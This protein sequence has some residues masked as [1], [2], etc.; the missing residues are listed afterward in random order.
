MTERTAS[1]AALVAGL[2]LLASTPAVAQGPRIAV[3]PQLGYQRAVDADEGR[4]MVGAALRLRVIPLLGAEGSI[5]YRR[6]RYSDGGITVRSWPIM[7]SGLVYPLP[8]LYGVAGFGWYNTS[9]DFESPQL[10]D[11]TT[12][13]VGWHF[14]GGLEL[15][16]GNVRLTGDIRYV[17]LDYD[18]SGAPGTGGTDADF[19][20]ITAG[21]LFRL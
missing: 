18:F 11:E 21:L 17:F 10:D 16:L 8:V 13:E 19:Y 3:G 14:G 9:F 6:E 1:A 15:P 4:L 5:N 2:S 7:V 12:R 20:V